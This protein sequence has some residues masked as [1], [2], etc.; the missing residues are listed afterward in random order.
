MDQSQLQWE[1]L[2]Q[3]LLREQDKEKLRQK[4]DDLEEAIFFRFQEL[5]GRPDAAETAKLKEATQTLLQIRIEKLGFPT[6]RSFGQGDV[7]Q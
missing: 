2:L 7:Q 4:A 5:N 6:S 3:D 1:C